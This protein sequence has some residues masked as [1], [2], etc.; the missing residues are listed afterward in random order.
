MYNFSF[1]LPSV[2]NLCYFCCEK[3]NTLVNLDVSFKQKMTGFTA[4]VVLCHHKLNMLSFGL[5]KTSL[6]P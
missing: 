1:L 4:F 3:D 5:L 2:M 6:S